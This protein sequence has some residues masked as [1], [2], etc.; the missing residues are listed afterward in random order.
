MTFTKPTRYCVEYSN[1]EKWDAL[2]RSGTEQ[3]DPVDYRD[4]IEAKTLREARKI[5]RLL[6]VRWPYAQPKIHRRSQI[7]AVS[8]DYTLD[9]VGEEAHDGE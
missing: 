9:D 2:H 5:A 4:W 8:W 6:L 3:A 7:T 1:V